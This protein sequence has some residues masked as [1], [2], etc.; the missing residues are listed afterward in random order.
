MDCY[1]FDM[2]Y[3][4]EAFWGA[5]MGN[6]DIKATDGTNIFARVTSGIDWWIKLRK[7]DEKWFWKWYDLNPGLPGESPDC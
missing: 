6:C 7:R 2:I 4:S 5:R 1:L 3:L